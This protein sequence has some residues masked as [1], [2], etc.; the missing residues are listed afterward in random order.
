MLF[1]N[2]CSAIYFTNSHSGKLLRTALSIIL[3]IPCNIYCRNSFT[4]LLFG[5][6]KLYSIISNNKNRDI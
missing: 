2:S 3:I 4:Y 1:I 5:I 6:F